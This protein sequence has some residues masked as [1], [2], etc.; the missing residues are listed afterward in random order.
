MSADRPGCRLT[1][2]VLAAQVDG[3]G[4][5]DRRAIT[6][7]LG[8]LESRDCIPVLSA[9]TQDDS[10]PVQVTA[11]LA[12][13]KLGELLGL[14][15]LETLRHNASWQTRQLIAGALGQTGAP[16][17]VEPLLDML[18]DSDYDVRMGAAKS[19]GLLGQGDAMPALRQAA[20]RDS[21]PG[22]QA[23]AAEALAELDEPGDRA[24]PLRLSRDNDPVKQY[25][26]ASGLLKMGDPAGLDILGQ[27]TINANE[28]IQRIAASALCA[29]KV[30]GP[31]RLLLAMARSTV[32]YVRAATARALSELDGPQ[33]LETL[34]DLATDQ[35][36]FVL[37]ADDPELFGRPAGANLTVAAAT[38]A[39]LG[40]SRSRE[41]EEVLLR[42]ADDPDPAV[43]KA[44][45]AALASRAQ[46]VDD[47]TVSSWA[48]DASEHVRE[49]AAE[50]IGARGA[51]GALDTLLALSE[52]QYIAVRAKALSALGRLG[53]ESALDPLISGLED[54]IWAVQCGAAA[55]LEAMAQ[56]AVDILIRRMDD[57]A[58][59]AN[60]I[61]LLDKLGEPEAVRP[62]IAARGTDEPTIW[63]RV[64]TEAIEADD[65]TIT[66]ALVA[67]LTN[68]NPRI[69]ETA[70]EALAALGGRDTVTPVAELMSDPNWEV[71]LT[72]ASTLSRI[73]ASAMDLM[74]TALH[75]GNRNVRAG[76]A[77]LLGRQRAPEAVDALVQALADPGL[78]VR[79]NAA[80][81]LGRIGDPR[82]VAP[83]T[84][85]M[86][87]PDRGVVNNA[88]A[89]L[90]RIGTPEAM[91]RV[92]DWTADRRRRA[93]AVP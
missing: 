40:P 78:L 2:A 52:D 72:A 61:W 71:R 54:R 1:I 59:P 19:L 82:A 15:T 35:A 48:Q 21:H 43:S 46:L 60:A 49:A 32:P 87:D 38:A 7:A 18:D 58:A 10:P 65:R 66:G 68:G 69:R 33:P 24:V 57:A 81:A 44:A 42:L 51:P 22:A 50:L 27:L 34:L 90:R 26:G 76:M 3:A 31:T 5:E 13:A 79:A 83:L 20:E 62:V 6:V 12:L 75:D 64:V 8:R 29:G 67:A 23:Y 80:E 47:E 70:A 88:A 86:E 89:A 77:S 73:G 14:A 25:L 92:R 37:F 56:L 93:P 36:G 84:R 30:R 17:A 53:D 63:Q 16:A 39:A 45:T 91:A 41:A 11:A 28:Y 74:V 9:L 4:S 85:A 55:G